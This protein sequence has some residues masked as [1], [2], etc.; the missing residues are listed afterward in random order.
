MQRICDKENFYHFFGDTNENSDYKRGWKFFLKEHE[1]D[2][3]SVSKTNYISNKWIDIADGVEI[4]QDRVYNHQAVA[5]RYNKDSI[6]NPMRHPLSIRA[7][8]K[9]TNEVKFYDMIYHC[10]HEDMNDENCIPATSKMTLLVK[11]WF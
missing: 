6:F 1:N 8:C 10:E 7:T 2:T 9:N 5:L 4:P 11:K 3:N